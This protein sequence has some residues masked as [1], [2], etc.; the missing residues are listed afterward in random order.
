MLR[1]LC[2]GEALVD[3][4][5]DRRK[6]RRLEMTA[7][8]GG[9]PANVA[10]F[11]S[12]LGLQTWLA[13][14]LGLDYFGRFV[15]SELEEAGVKLDYSLQMD[16]DMLMAI[17]ELGQ[18]G[19]P[20]Y[21]FRRDRRIVDVLSVDAFSDLPVGQFDLVH[22]GSLGL[23]YEPERQAYLALV[24]RAMR[25]G[26]MLSLDPNVRWAS[27]VDFDGYRKV[28]LDLVSKVDIFKASRDDL[29][30]LF[31]ADYLTKLKEQRSGRPTFITEG[32]LGSTV[33]HGG[34]QAHLPQEQTEVVDTTGCGDAYMAAILRVLLEKEWSWRNMT[35]AARFGNQ[36]AAIV[37][38]Y[39]GATG[40]T[41]LL[42]DI[43]AAKTDI[44]V[45]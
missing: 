1:V 25:E 26:I 21:S 7:Y 24:E 10:T 42:G 37:A 8:P 5:I 27:G 9:A 13:T 35:E 2:V 20:R 23:L 12:S 18:A 43:I 15:R 31:G 29:V 14:V 36:V 19:V 6:D 32:H 41:A 16:M 39:P 44:V 34:N 22:C 17:V 33:V 38:A 28:M 3:V 11:L 30:A 40:A 45:N 4:V